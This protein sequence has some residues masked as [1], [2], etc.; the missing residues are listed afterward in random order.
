MRISDWSSD[1]CSS[2]LPTHEV[3]LTAALWRILPPWDEVWAKHASIPS[4]GRPVSDPTLGFFGSDAVWGWPG[5]RRFSALYSGILTSGRET[6][7]RLDSWRLLLGSSGN[8]SSWGGSGNYRLKECSGV[9]VAS[10]PPSP[11]ASLP[12]AVR[13][14]WASWLHLKARRQHGRFC[15]D[16]HQEPF[17]SEHSRPDCVPLT[18]I[19]ILQKSPCPVGCS[20]W[21]MLSA[22]FSF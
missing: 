15:T 4:T 20:I 1:V 14:G 6:P 11:A 2:D 19:Y 8:W 7:E 21:L 10:P 13:V 3:Q 5:R 17:G 9:P 22:Q 18:F 12:P 16:T